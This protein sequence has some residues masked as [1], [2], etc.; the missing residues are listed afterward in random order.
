M[1]DRRCGT[2]QGEWQGCYRLRVGDHR[3]IF[4]CLDDGLEIITIGHR[5]QIY[6]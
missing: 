1:P 5:S 4:R 2:A 3:V 6:K